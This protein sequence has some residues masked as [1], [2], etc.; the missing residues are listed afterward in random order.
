METLTGAITKISD[1]STQIEKIIKTI[2]DIAFQTNI[3][4]LNAA[5]EAA[6]AGES[7]KGFAVVA[8]EVRNLAGKSADAAKNTMTLVT[9]STTAVE[10]GSAYTLETD[11]ALHTIDSSMQEFSQLMASITQATQ[12]QADA[13]RN[14][15]EGLDH[16]TNAV[17]S[18]A[19]TAQQS[20]ASSLELNEQADMLNKKVSYYKI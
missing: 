16:I 12:E 9:R 5:V 7:G 4:A 3:L 20:A 11:E 17:Q 1:A 2:E 14:I 8:D 15:S 19:A 18:N 6:R 13:I 10:K